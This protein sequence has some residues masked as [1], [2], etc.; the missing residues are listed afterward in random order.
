MVVH[1]GV[2]LNVAKLVEQMKRS[3]KS[4]TAHEQLLVD[5]RKQNQE[6]TASNTKSASK[7]KEASADLKSTSRKLSDAETS[8]ASLQRKSSEYQALLSSIHE[9][10]GAV[11]VVKKEKDKDRS[12]S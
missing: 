8:L 5:L 6:L 3:E 4:L 1:N 10:V 11:L 9:K 12:E 7:L 2:L